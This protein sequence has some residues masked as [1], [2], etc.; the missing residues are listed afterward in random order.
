MIHAQ[1]ALTVQE[2]PV[3]DGGVDDAGEAD[4]PGTGLADSGRN[5]HPMR[6][7]GLILRNGRSLSFVVIE[8]VLRETAERFQAQGIFLIEARQEF[9]VAAAIRKM[10]ES[11]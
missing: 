11:E 3:D 6:I 10:R 5:R 1:M 8:G 9:G 2:E 7:V 4:H